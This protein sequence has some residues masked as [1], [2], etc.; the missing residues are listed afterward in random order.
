MYFLKHY[1]M[2]FRLRPPPKNPP[3]LWMKVLVDSDPGY[4]PE[5]D[6]MLWQGMM[7]NRNLE[8]FNQKT[9]VLES[10]KEWRT[11]HIEEPRDI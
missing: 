8:K 1:F 3:L 10:G 6:G 2:R 9:A 4:I 11:S 5:K 7:E